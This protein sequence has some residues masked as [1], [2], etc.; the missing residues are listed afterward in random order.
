MRA[1]WESVGVR[2]RPAKWEHFEEVI[3]GLE[4]KW[5]VV[6]AER[7][8]GVDISVDI[9]GSRSRADDGRSEGGE[10]LK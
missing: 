4:R 8:P 3:C 7:K 2:A 6:V 9:D 10:L 1:G 5:V